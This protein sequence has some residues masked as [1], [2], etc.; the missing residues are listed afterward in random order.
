LGDEIK[1]PGRNIPR[2]L[3]L[4]II[5]VACLYVVM[6]IS[7]LGVVPWR[8]MAQAGTSNS[9]LYVVSTFMQ[10]TIGSRAGAIVSVLIMWTAFASVFSL[11]LG[12]SRVP[13]A[14]ATDGNY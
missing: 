5:A 8:E 4:S 6:N 7:I 11:M 9:K 1:N 12:Y 10:R 14:A 13:Y 2:A 3:L